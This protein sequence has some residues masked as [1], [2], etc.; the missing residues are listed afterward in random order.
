MGRSS[1]KRTRLCSKFILIYFS[2]LALK[3]FVIDPYLW[4]GVAFWKISKRRQNM[5]ARNQTK[6]KILEKNI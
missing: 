4:A 6:I 2:N 1:S 5:A 3:M